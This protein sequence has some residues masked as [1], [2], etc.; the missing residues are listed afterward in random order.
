M[1]FIIDK[2]IL[3]DGKTIHHNRNLSIFGGASLCMMAGTLSTRF[4]E[5]TVDRFGLIPTLA[6][7]V[8]ITWLVTEIIYNIAEVILNGEEILEKI[9]AV[10]TSLKISG[11][12]FMAGLFIDQ[13]FSIKKIAEALLKKE[14]PGLDPNM[15]LIGITAISAIIAAIIL[16]KIDYYHDSEDGPI[17]CLIEWIMGIPGFIKD[18]GIVVREPFEK[19]KKKKTE[20]NEIMTIVRPLGEEPDEDNDWPGGT[21]Q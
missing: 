19:K 10:L 13:T 20:D 15:V 12:I 14:M 21:F 17:A 18:V 8:A 9:L 4:C 5:L 1:G 11:L 2:L 7:A 3:D 6:V 16:I